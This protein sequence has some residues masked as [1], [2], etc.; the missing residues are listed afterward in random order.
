MIAPSGS[1]YGMVEVLANGTVS[2]AG[3]AS[4]R[5]SFD[6]GDNWNTH[7]LDNTYFAAGGITL[8]DGTNE[9]HIG[10]TAAT[11][12]IVTSGDKY[13]FGLADKNYDTPNP[14]LELQVTSPIDDG[15]GGTTQTS[16]TY[17][18]TT[19]EVENATSTL[20]VVQLDTVNGSWVVGEIDIEFTAVVAA[21]TFT[22]VVEFDINQSG[23]IGNELTPLTSISPFYDD[24]GSF[25]IATSGERIYVKNMDNETAYFD[26][27]PTTTIREVKEGLESAIASLFDMDLNSVSKDKLA[28]YVTSADSDTFES[29]S[30]KFVIRSPL[31]GTQGELFIYST[32]DDIDDAFSFVDAQ[33][34]SG[35]SYFARINN[36][37]YNLSGGE[38]NGVIEGV[39]LEIDEDDLL[40][41]GWS[42]RSGNFV[43]NPNN[44]ADATVSVKDNRQKYLSSINGGVDDFAIP[45][46][47]LDS[48]NLD[49]LDVSTL[50]LSSR[51]TDL[52]NLALNKMNSFKGSLGG[53]IKKT[54]YRL[55]NT[56][57]N[58][59]QTTSTISNLFSTD[60]AMEYAE[61]TKRLMLQNIITSMYSTMQDYSRSIYSILG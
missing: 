45:D 34:A 37:D 53:E 21:V 12:I 19:S 2:A 47:S 3:S 29:T 11:G 31:A 14:H 52:I 40:D 7:T 51:A 22:S 24:D 39:K 13:L 48:L 27:L 16:M 6:N 41:V 8:T 17:S 15:S 60:V 28:T 50:D 18:R 55:D 43:F 57:N 36:K 30:G 54:S 26:I 56:E 9:L 1:G 49:K 4:I 35:E 61:M 25:K 44:G 58:I 59:A 33:A 46:F 38:L 10:D 42:G 23:G 5:F 20:D 32:N